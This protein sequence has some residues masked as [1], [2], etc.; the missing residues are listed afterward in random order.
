M[1]GS[2]TSHHLGGE[3]F[4]LMAGVEIVHVP[5]K[6]TAPARARKP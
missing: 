2:G 4:K 3:L 1:L 6:G 5:Y